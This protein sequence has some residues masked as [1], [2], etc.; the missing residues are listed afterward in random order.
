[1]VAHVYRLQ[2]KL[3]AFVRSDLLEPIV[4]QL[5]IIAL[6][7]RVIQALVY[8]LTLVTRVFVRMVTQVTTA[9][10]QLTFV[11]RHRVKTEDFVCN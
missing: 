1:M 7:I 6:L 3:N 5:L 2:V 10:L 9:R 4:N 11:R 8:H